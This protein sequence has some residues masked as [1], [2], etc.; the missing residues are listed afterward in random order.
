MVDSTLQSMS[1]S[2][3][4][5]PKLACRPLLWAQGTYQTCKIM[6][7]LKDRFPSCAYLLWCR[8]VMS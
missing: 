8:N 6:L 3:P 2:C 5:S 7:R 4:I 1:T